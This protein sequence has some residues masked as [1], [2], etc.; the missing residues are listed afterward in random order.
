[1]SRRSSGRSGTRTPRFR[2][3]HRP[4]ADLRVPRSRLY[5]RLFRT[6]RTLF[7]ANH[8]G[9]HVLSA[10]GRS[11]R[12]VDDLGHGCDHAL[13][14][15]VRSAGRIRCGLELG[16]FGKQAKHE[17]GIERPGVCG[18]GRVAA[19]GVRRISAAELGG[20]AGRPEGPLDRGHRRARAGRGRGVSP[21][22]PGETLA[23]AGGS[24]AGFFF[25]LRR[26]AGPTRGCGR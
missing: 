3:A 11:L 17:R 25:P 26:R 12:T 14:R 24:R 16:W 4:T 7:G 9:R 20:A 18:L 21:A 10:R 13:W 5:V 19:P 23:G 8:S 15:R 22:G 2:H 1:M 6:T